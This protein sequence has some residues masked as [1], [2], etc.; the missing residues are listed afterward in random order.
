MAWA[1]AN[2]IVNGVSDTAFAPNRDITREQL[3]AMLCRYA[4]YKGKDTTASGSLSAFTDASDVSAYAVDALTWA[5][6]VELV[7]GVGNNTIAPQ[8]TAT[9]AQAATMLMRFAE[10]VLA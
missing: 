2:G 1:A 5:V 10:N 7:N 3:A 6:D 8:N 9:R 4:A